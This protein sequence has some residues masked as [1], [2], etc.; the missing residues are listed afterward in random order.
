MNKEEMEQTIKGLQE[1]QENAIKLL[2]EN[3]RLKRIIKEAYKI[4]DEALTEQMITGNATI[5]LV[6]LCAILKGDKNE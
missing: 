4:L 1:N 6:E 2:E 5:N 3:V